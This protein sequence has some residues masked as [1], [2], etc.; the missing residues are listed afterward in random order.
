[1]RQYSV[2]L[3]FSFCLTPLLGQLTQ[4]ELNFPQM[5]VGGSPAYETVLQILNAVETSNAIT[6]DVFQGSSSPSA[7]GTPLQVRFDGGAPESSR[8]VTLTPFQEFTTVLS[9]SD[10]TSR[11]GWIRVRSSTA[12]GKMSGNLLFR[13]K[14]GA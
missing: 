13:V 8:S 3:V 12:G 4:S 9:A 1:M 5:A 7:N 14:N 6:I 11:N 10:A 2:I